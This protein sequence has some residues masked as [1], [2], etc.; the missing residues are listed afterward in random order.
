MGSGEI[1]FCAVVFLMC[2]VILVS[3]ANIICVVSSFGGQKEKLVG[4]DC[5]FVFGTVELL[6]CDVILVSVLILLALGRKARK[7]PK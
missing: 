2:D 5:I 4:Q 6:R 1:S 7:A 3:I